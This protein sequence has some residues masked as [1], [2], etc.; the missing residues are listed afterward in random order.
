MREDPGDG[1]QPGE[2]ERNIEED[3]FNFRVGYVE[4]HCGKTQKKGLYI[5]LKKLNPWVRLCYSWLSCY[6]MLTSL[7]V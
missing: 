3:T 4:T 7:L 2:T 1:E 6:R 5:F